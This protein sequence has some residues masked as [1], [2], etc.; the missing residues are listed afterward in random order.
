MFS[1]SFPFLSRKHITK[2]RWRG[3]QLCNKPLNVSYTSSNSD[4]TGWTMLG[5]PVLCPDEPQKKTS[6]T[7]TSG[8][9]EV[10][11][12]F[13]EDFCLQI[14]QSLHLQDVKSSTFPANSKWSSACF[15]RGVCQ[16]APLLSAT[17]SVL[18]ILGF[19]YTGR[20]SPPDPLSQLLIQQQIAHLFPTVQLLVLARHTENQ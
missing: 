20:T 17:E 3:L 13:T 7:T 1:L 9:V 19:E 15:S 2:H 16:D 8:V 4:C 5:N 11:N 6:L 10:L 18:N 12:S 14:V